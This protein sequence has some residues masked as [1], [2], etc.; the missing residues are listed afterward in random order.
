[1][2]KIINTVIFYLAAFI[3]IF[4]IHFLSPTN[5]S[6]LGLD[7]FVYIVMSVISV[8]LLG[9]SISN[10]GPNDPSSRFLLYINL[11]GTTIVALLIVFRTR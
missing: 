11:V 2:N 5:S 6:G 8:A 7:I 9:K 3:I 10:M 4:S 1:M